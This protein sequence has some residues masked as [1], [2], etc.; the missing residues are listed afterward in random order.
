M[1]QLSKKRN[2]KSRVRLIK[3]INETAR[4]NVETCKKEKRSF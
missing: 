4:Y 3:E 1:R 2:K